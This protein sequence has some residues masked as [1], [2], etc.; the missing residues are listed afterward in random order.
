MVSLGSW[1]RIFAIFQLC[2]IYGVLIDVDPS[3]FHFTVACLGVMFVL[4]PSKYL[5]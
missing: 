1:L 3:C 5:P 2:N 4:A